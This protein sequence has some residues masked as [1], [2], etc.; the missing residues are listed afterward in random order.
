MYKFLLFIVCIHTTLVL[1]GDKPV[2]HTK[3]VKI[4][5][6]AKPAYLK[7]YIDP[8]FKSKVTRIT[9]EPGSKIPNTTGTWHQV[10]RHRY[11]K[12]AAWNCDQSLIFL[13]THHGFPSMLFLDGTTYKPVFGRN[14]A[15]GT[16]IR[17]HPLKPNIMVFVKNNTIGYWNVRDEKTEIITTFDGYS[18]FHIGPW[19]GN[20]SNDG[21]MIVITG[22]KG[23][24]HIS[25]AY[26][27]DKK[28]KYPNLVL[29]DFKVDW[30]SISASGKY[31][32]IN[33]HING[34]NGDQTQVYNL[35]GKKVGKLWSEYGRPSH[36]DLTVGK[37]GDDIAVGVSKSK[38]DD[39]RV[40]KRR[41]KDG[42]VTVLTSGGY[43]SHTSARNLKRPGWVY[44]TYQHR[45]PTWAPYFDEVVAV[46]LDG[47]KTVE[48][49]AH[50][51]TKVTDYLTQAHAVPS[52]DGKR[53]LWASNWEDKSGRPLS[54]YVAERPLS[55][56]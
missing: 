12:N 18:E 25:F 27:L 48:R 39:G 41:L 32:V 21:K 20:L 55:K 50:L 2:T 54:S 24:K 26:N 56:K 40:I 49:I 52:P 3:I 17:W 44:V 35:R 6:I 46:K 1:A 31:I 36:Y 15:P 9:G 28:K 29:D 30:A 45:G 4:P 14:Q 19:E 16:E 5:A 22:K 8:V 53:V 43:A 33:G 10:A 37:K 51:H 47:K 11:S 7:S 42:K 34:K 38:P 13:G 23:E